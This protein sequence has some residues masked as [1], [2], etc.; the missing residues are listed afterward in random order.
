MAGPDT[1]TQIDEALH[2]L[3]RRVGALEAKN[4]GSGGAGSTMRLSD[5]TPRKNSGIGSAGE[6]GAAAR[7]DH[8]H[9]AVQWADIQDRPAITGEDKTYRHVQAI[10]VDTWVIGHGLEKYPTVAAVDTSGAVI[11]G[12]LHYTSLNALTITFSAVVSGEAYCN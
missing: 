2:A 1:I 6:I 5:E 12:E 9:P 8:A 3:R 11:I 7:G 4:G 10:A